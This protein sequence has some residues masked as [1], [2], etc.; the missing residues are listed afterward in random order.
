[1]NNAQ[2]VLN[3]QKCAKKDHYAVTTSLKCLHQILTLPSAWPGDLFHHLLCSVGELV[4]FSLS[5]VSLSAY[6]YCNTWFLPVSLNHSGNSRLTSLINKALLLSQLP[7]MGWFFLACKP[8]RLVC[9]SPRRLAPTI[10]PQ[11]LGSHLF[12]ILTYGQNN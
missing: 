8:H 9:E 5:L 12:S 1:M 3:G 4:S 2:L 7:L 6:L 10:I 11:S